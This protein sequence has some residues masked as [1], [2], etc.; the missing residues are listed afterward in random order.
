VFAEC[1]W[2][3]WEWVVGGCEGVGGSEGG[4]EGVDG[5]LLGSRYSKGGSIAVLEWMG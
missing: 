2:S 3:S 5:C 4:E 1:L